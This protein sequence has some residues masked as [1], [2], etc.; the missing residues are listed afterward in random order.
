MRFVNAFAIGFTLG[1]IYRIVTAVYRVI[2]DDSYECID[3]SC[4]CHLDQE[5]LD[6]ATVTE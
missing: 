1:G 3:D 2:S 5:W 4:S 6:A